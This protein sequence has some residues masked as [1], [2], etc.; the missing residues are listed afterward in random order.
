MRA[1]ADNCKAIFLGAV[2]WSDVASSLGWDWFAGISRCSLILTIAEIVLY[3]KE[4]R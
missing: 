1:C 2:C 4:C 3:T